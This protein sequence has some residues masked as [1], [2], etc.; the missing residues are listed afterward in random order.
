MHLDQ[1]V[2]VIRAVEQLPEGLDPGVVERAE[3]H[4]VAEAASTTP[5]T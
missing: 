5:S 1:A 3:E 4:L 2:E